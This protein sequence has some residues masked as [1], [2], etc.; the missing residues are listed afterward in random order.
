M[1]EYVTSKCHSINN[2]KGS[3]PLVIREQIDYRQI[4][5]F[6]TYHAPTVVLEGRSN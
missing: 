3:F 1:G 4:E 6:S 2:E 5:L